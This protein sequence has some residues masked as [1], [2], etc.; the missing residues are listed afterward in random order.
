MSPH[1]PIIVQPFGLLTLISYTS[2]FSIAAP[3]LTGKITFKAQRKSN[4]HDPSYISICFSFR[5]PSHRSIWP[6]TQQSPSTFYFKIP[7]TFYSQVP[8]TL[9]LTDFIPSALRTPLIFS[10]H[11][12]LLPP[13]AWYDSKIQI[14]QV[15]NNDTTQIDASSCP[16]SSATSAWAAIVTIR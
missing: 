6:S 1:E 8:F 4:L 2:L 5:L 12:P 9:C 11:V 15:D 3:A 13:T 16:L 14:S 10:L 7:F